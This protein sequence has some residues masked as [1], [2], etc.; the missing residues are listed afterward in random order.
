MPPPPPPPPPP[1][2][3]QAGDKAK[4]VIRRSVNERA[5]RDAG[6]LIIL[7]FSED[8][9]S[10]L[11]TERGYADNNIY[12][13]VEGRRNLQKRPRIFAETRDQ[14]SQNRLRQRAGF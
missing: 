14:N 5:K 8:G 2:V 10:G 11:K 13:A 7:T 12:A 9:Q 6:C 4:S 1:H 3:A